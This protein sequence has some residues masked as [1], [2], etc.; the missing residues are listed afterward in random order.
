MIIKTRYGI[1]RLNISINM[2][3]FYITFAEE[4]KIC[5]LMHR[6]ILPTNELFSQ[7]SWTAWWLQAEMTC[8]SGNWMIPLPHCPSPGCSQ[9]CC[10]FVLLVFGIVIWIPAHH[11]WVLCCFIFALTGA[12]WHR[13]PLLGIFQCTST[14]RRLLLKPFISY[15]DRHW[16]EISSEDLESF[17][18]ERDVSSPH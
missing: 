9:L 13:H 3:A 8:N 5:L 6:E 12:C 11:V 18:G 10:S 14:W 17:T 4:E 15:L 1:I 2:Q 16:F 7:W